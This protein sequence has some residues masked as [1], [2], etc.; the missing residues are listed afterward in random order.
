MST[1][2]CNLLVTGS[3]NSSRRKSVLPAPRK[4]ERTVTDGFLRVDEEDE[5]LG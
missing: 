1:K 3:G 2:G 5:C 4:P